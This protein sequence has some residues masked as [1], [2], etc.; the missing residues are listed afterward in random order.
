MAKTLDKKLLTIFKWLIILLPLFIFICLFLYPKILKISAINASSS[1]QGSVSQAQDAI[2]EDAFQDIEY[3]N[4][5]GDMYLNNNLSSEFMTWFTSSDYCLWSH[6]VFYKLI[7]KIAILTNGTLICE[8]HLTYFIA[9]YLDYVIFIEVIFM[10]LYLFRFFIHFGFDL[11]ER[12]K[13]L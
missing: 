3:F 4:T 7:N 8:N 5:D 11:F 2:G 12:K 6:G 13:E 1:G 10:G 9:T